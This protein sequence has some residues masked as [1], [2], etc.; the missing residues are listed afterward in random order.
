MKIVGKSSDEIIER[1]RCGSPINVA[2]LIPPVSKL[3]VGVIAGK[4]FAV[5]GEGPD[6]K[7]TAGNQAY[8]PLRDR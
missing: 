6:G 1:K 7:N 5:G 8:D 2:W 4:V 3:A